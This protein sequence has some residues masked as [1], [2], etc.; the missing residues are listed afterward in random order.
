MLPCLCQFPLFHLV[1]FINNKNTAERCTGW[2]SLR[3]GMNT[4][5]DTAKATAFQDGHILIAM[6]SGV[7]VRFSVSG[8][9]RLIRHA[10]SL[11]DHAVISAI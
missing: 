11:N 2:L 4:L 6:E 9:P 1:S 8:N 10:L 3:L 7:E 5:V